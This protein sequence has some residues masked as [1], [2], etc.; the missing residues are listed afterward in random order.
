[1]T[2]DYDRSYDLGSLGSQGSHGAEQL[3]SRRERV[4]E[5]QDASPS[6]A[7]GNLKLVGIENAPIGAGATRQNLRVPSVEKP[8]FGDYWREGYA[9]RRRHTRRNIPLTDTCRVPLHEQGEEGSQSR[10]ETLASWRVQRILVHAEMT[11]DS[12]V[13]DRHRD[14]QD[15]WRIEKVRLSA[16]IAGR[17]GIGSA[18][19]ADRTD[20]CLA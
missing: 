1:M 12:S 16:G 19:A 14:G 10:R 20:P 17:V 15:W 11:M 4:V 3:R 7:V 18:A 8:E 5:K 9:S 2:A 13:S 6:N